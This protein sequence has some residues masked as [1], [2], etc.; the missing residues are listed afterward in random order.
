MT[1]SF[2]FEIQNFENAFGRWVCLRKG[3]WVDGGMGGF[4]ERVDSLMG[5]LCERYGWIGG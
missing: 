5:G 3:G 4:K 1:L 2:L